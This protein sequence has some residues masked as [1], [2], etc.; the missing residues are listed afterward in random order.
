MRVHGSWVEFAKTM[1]GRR[2]YA[3]TTAGAKLYTDIRYAPEPAAGAAIR[4]TTISVASTKPA[5]L[6]DNLTK[7]VNYI[8]QVRPF[9]KLGFSGWSGSAERMCI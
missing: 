9:G 7:G 5:T 8:F 2:M 4:W 1:A 6:I 3:F